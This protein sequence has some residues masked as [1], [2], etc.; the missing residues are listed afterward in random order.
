M[1]WNRSRRAIA[2]LGL[3]TLLIAF[4]FL[5]NAGFNGWEGGFGIGSRYLVIAIP[6]FGLMI[7]EVRGGLR[8]LVTAIGILS[9]FL[10]L[11]AVAVDPQPSGSIPRPMEQYLLPLLFTGRFSER[12]PLTPPWSA[13]TFTGHTS[14]NR[15]AADEPAPFVTA[16][17]DSA[18]AEWASFNL[19]EPFFGPGSAASLLPIV[20]IIVI[21]SAAILRKAAVE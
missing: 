13:A 9:I 8:H 17:P 20:L 10:S 7:L 11:A 12:V 21:A 4:W 3:I 2:E 1:F 6:F 15:V 16:A 19:G 5:F 18:A 14:V